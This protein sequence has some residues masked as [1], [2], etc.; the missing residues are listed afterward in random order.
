MV[1]ERFSKVECCYIFQPVKILD[2]HRFVQSE[3][4]S[5]RFYCLRRDFRVHS[6]LGKI[7]SR[8]YLDNHKGDKGHPK[9]KGN[10]L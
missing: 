2:H 1:G 8:R 7:V 3:V 9:Q 4:S 5:H 10:K 6:H